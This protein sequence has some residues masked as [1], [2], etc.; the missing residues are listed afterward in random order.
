MLRVPD[1][2]ELMLFPIFWVSYQQ[3]RISSKNKILKLFDLSL[4]IH[5]YFIQCGIKS[6]D[7]VIGKL[8]KAIDRLPTDKFFSCEWIA[9]QVK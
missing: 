3:T 5:F 4:D 6:F 9:V 2:L 7:Y 1:V 8:S